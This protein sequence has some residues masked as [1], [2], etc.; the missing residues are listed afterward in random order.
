MRP[1]G[2]NLRRRAGRGR[3]AGQPGWAERLAGN[4]EEDEENV[5]RSAHAWNYSLNR[6]FALESKSQRAD[7]RF[8][9]TKIGSQT[10]RNFRFLLLEIGSLLL[11]CQIYGQTSELVTI[12]SEVDR[13]F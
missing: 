3:R 13:F 9:I 12:S 10:A 5:E 6:T 7:F 1:G 2:R 8:Y 11:T 4:Q